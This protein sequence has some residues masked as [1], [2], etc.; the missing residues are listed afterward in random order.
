MT[1]EELNQLLE[2][3]QALGSL[4]LNNSTPTYG[5]PQVSPVIWDD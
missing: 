1:Q 2:E 5:L 4:V 3:L